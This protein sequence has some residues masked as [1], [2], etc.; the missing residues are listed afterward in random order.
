MLIIFLLMLYQ[1]IEFL[2][3]SLNFNEHIYTFFAFVVI[4]FLPPL[5]L[6]LIL[7]FFN[8]YEK[9]IGSIFILSIV[10]VIFY[11]LI[12]NHFE[13]LKCTAFYASY[14]YPLGDLYGTYYYLPILISIIVL[15]I[16]I[17]AHEA[18]E[19]TKLAKILLF[20]YIFVSIPVILAFILL[21][22]N[23]HQLVNI[24]E[25]VMCKFALVLAICLSYF[26]L[27]YK[28]AVK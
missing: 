3:C 17:N 23:N 28:T 13:I 24:I 27:R 2:I 11:G 14:H 5:T 16:K 19:K 15:I 26:S 8:L 6:I 10:F 7:E 22:F 25:S 18:E 1:L 4:T 21:I 12:I 20:G 9:W